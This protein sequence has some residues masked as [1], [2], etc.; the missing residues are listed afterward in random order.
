MHKVTL[1]K[2]LVP[3]SRDLPERPRI[4]ACHDLTQNFFLACK[5]VRAARILFQMR[6]D[7]A[8]YSGYVHD[9]PGSFQ[10][11]LVH[12]DRLLKTILMSNLGYGGL[13]RVEVETRD[14]NDAVASGR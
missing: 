2:N 8:T 14:V 7:V 12:R 6:R 4:H 3:Y 11:K 5:L 9:G 1:Y 10:I 13:L